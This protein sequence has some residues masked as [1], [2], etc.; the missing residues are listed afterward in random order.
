MTSTHPTL[1]NF[2]FTPLEHIRP[3]GEPGQHQ[4]HW[5]G[6][7][8]GQ[9]WIQAGPTALL[10]YSEI[11]RTHGTPRYCSYQVARLYEDLLD[12]I[13]SVV[14]PVPAYLIPYL[15]GDHSIAWESTFRS[16]YEK[17]PNGLDKPQ[18][19]D[20][21][22]AASTWIVKRTLDTSYL[23]QSAKIR[24]WF[25][26]RLVHLAWDNTL[27]TFQGMPVWSAARGSLQLPL[28]D[29]ISELTSFHTRLMEQMSER[30][31]QV[32][33]GALPDNVHVD[34]AGL[35][36]EHQYRSHNDIGHRTVP[37][38]T[39]WSLVGAALAQIGADGQHNR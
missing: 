20:L 39:D 32:L 29:F 22:D 13:P 34:L 17:A 3:W 35:T 36:R 2:E 25:D 7:T 1:F 21:A 5:F 24:L 27:K 4:L 23:S 9:Y 8:D 37:T 31:T 33:A 14:E 10:E 11:A 26:G 38:Q 16:W 30:V 19:W 12:L 15:W 18:F 28:E 6:L